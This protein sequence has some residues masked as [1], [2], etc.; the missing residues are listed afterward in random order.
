MIKEVIVV[1]GKDDITAVKAAVECEVIATGGFRFSDKF[2]ERLRFIQKQKGIIVLTDP[3]YAGE[4]IRAT[5]NRKVRG[6]KNA[7]I[8]QN[9][10]IYKKDI[11]VE[12]AKPEDIVEAIF[13]AKVTVEEKRSEFT[14]EDLVRYKLT[15]YPISKR[16]REFLGE[17]L[18]IGYCNGKQFLARLN[19]YDVKREELERLLGEFC[20]E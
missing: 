3:D 9:K 6:V 13:N 4:K 12:N 20:D 5:I 14:I 2:I 8:P 15:G 1:E 11:G 16:R 17:K 18:N 7:Y 19:K 10:A